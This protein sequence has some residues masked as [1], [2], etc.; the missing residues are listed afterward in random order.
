[1]FAFLKPGFSVLHSNCSLVCFDQSE[2][3]VNKKSSRGRKKGENS[4][5][6]RDVAYEGHYPA[7]P[8]YLL[9]EAKKKRLS[10][11]WRE[12]W[13][14]GNIKYIYIFFF[15]RIFGGLSLSDAGNYEGK[16][17]S[18][19]TCNLK[20]AAGRQTEWTHKPFSLTLDKHAT[21]P[22]QHFIGKKK[23]GDQ[24][25]YMGLVATSQHLKRIRVIREKGI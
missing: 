20:F 24:G 11:R 9:Q 1:M 10:V 4:G 12:E 15:S 23:T 3:K 14:T 21:S 13:R 25:L 19:V 22:Q 5:G 18:T 16:W 6:I 2:H 17:Q 7:I 8:C